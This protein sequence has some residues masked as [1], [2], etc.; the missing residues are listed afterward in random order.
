M[1]FPVKRKVTGVNVSLA[2]LGHCAGYFYV[3]LTQARLIWEEGSSVKETSH[4]IILL[5]IFLIND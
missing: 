2:R 1:A 4:Q 5:F 3:N